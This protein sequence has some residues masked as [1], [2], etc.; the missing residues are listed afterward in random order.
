ME[1]REL[2]IEFLDSI[3]EYLMESDADLKLDDRESSEFVDIFLA[4]GKEND[5]NREIGKTS[6]T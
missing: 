6:R 2:L 3:R 4:K 5:T 1:Q